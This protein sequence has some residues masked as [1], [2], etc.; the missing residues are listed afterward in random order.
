MTN[1]LSVYQNAF[2]IINFR[3]CR[4]RLLLQLHEM[5]SS[6]DQLRFLRSGAGGVWPRWRSV[7]FCESRRAH[8]GRGITGT[9][10]MRGTAELAGQVL[11]ENRRTAVGTEST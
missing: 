4:Y 7:L 2:S 3:Y 6:F 11:V 8:G 9:A 1:S 5:A 10:E